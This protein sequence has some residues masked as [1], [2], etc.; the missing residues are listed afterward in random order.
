MTPQQ[1]VG[2]INFLTKINELLSGKQGPAAEIACRNAS[3]EIEKIIDVLK[4]T[5]AA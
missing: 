4:E 3:A 5:E 2:F 1:Q